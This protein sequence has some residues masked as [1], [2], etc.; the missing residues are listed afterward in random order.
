MCVGVFHFDMFFHERTCLFVPLNTHQRGHRPS[1]LSLSPVK[2]TPSPDPPTHQSTYFG[3]GPC[4]LVS[5]RTDFLTLT[6]RRTRNLRVFF[7][8]VNAYQ[9]MRVE[10][11]LLP[12]GWDSCV[13]SAGSSVRGWSSGK[14]QNGEC[15]STR[16]ARFIGLLSWYSAAKL[17]SEVPELESI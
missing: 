11:N 6:S 14:S 4:L 7:Q 8:F 3:E 5:A 1:P 10:Y 2:T 17:S 16:L 9:Q 12:G 15:W 13:L